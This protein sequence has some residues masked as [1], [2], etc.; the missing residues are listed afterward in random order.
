MDK[1]DI[2]QLRLAAMK[3]EK[4]DLPLARNLISIASSFAPNDRLL[5]MKLSDYEHMITNN[6]TSKFNI[7]S[8][9][10]N[11]ANDK[12]EE[13]YTI[14]Q[15][16]SKKA[17][18]TLLEELGVIYN[19]YETLKAKIEK[20]YP[21]KLESKKSNT[22]IFIMSSFNRFMLK[23]YPFK[24][25][26]LYICDKNTSYYTA[27]LI[28]TVDAIYDFISKNHY[29]E[30]ILLGASKSGYG[31]LLWQNLLAKK[32][33]KNVYSISVN[34]FTKLFPINTYQFE[35]PSY[36]KLIDKYYSDSYTKNTLDKYGDLKN[37]VT[38]KDPKNL[39][40]Y[41]AK[42]HRDVQDYLRISDF[43]TGYP[44]QFTGHTLLPFLTLKTSVKEKNGV[45]SIYTQVE[46]LYKKADSD[47]DLKSGLPL[48]KNEYIEECSNSIPQ[49]D[50]IIYKF[51]SS[52]STNVETAE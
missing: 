49:L 38:N 14:E 41:S 6:G 13:Q 39:L 42:G 21:I 3:L 11:N 16:N 40:I 20:D 28:D 31:A 30:V 24:Y 19:D 48:N 45:E 37:L 26:C 7:G 8:S 33:L 22:L 52:F 12:K 27:R 5:A 23:N 17:Q 29:K 1:S 15:E 2:L 18:E 35:T 32:G 47:Q 46:E 4:V 25:D 9:T 10:L 43:V 50:E 51:L 44:I 36:R 34:P